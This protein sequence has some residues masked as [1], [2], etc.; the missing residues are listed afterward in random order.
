MTAD[1]AKAVAEALGQQMQ[2]E[3]MT[4]Y[5]VLAAIPE[6]QQGLQAGAEQPHGLGAG[7]APLPVRRLVP[8]RRPHRRV[9]A[10]AA[11]RAGADGDGPRRLVQEGVPEAARAACW[12]WS[13]KLTQIVD[14]FGMKMP[15][16]QFLVSR[17]CTWCTIAASSPRTC[18]RWAARCR[19]S[20]AAAT[21]SRGERN[22]GQLNPSIALVPRPSDDPFSCRSPSSTG[23]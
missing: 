13:R 22:R 4:T 5:K 12:R 7:H 14:F 16:A 2:N 19:A 15:A 17:S 11:G 6:G 20:T 23:S 8:R 21:T 10:R 18:A 9:R 1:Q 3:W